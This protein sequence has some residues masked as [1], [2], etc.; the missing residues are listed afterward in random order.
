MNILKTSPNNDRVQGGD[1]GHVVNDW[2]TRSERMAASHVPLAG[3]HYKAVNLHHIR[4]IPTYPTQDL[5]E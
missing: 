3:A 4:S 5:S 2:R 1:E